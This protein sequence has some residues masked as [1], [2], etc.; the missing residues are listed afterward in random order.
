M[1]AGSQSVNP[2]NTK[3]RKASARLKKSGSVDD[4]AGV[5]YNMI[6]S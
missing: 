6:R 2:S 3:S 1:K 5:F 4:A